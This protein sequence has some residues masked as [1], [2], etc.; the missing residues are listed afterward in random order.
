MFTELESNETLYKT[1][2]KACFDNKGSQTLFN[3]CL[4]DFN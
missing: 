2:F 4:F 3:N 1:Y